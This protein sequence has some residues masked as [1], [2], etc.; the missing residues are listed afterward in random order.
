M[1]NSGKVIFYAADK[2]REIMLAR[3]FESGVKAMGEAFEIRRKAEYGENPDGSDRKY[4]GPTPDDTAVAICFGVKADQIFWDHRA[5]GIPVVYIDKGWSRQGG[6]GGHTLYSRCAVNASSPID[7]MMGMGVTH[8]RWER[9]GVRLAPYRA[10]DGGHI[11]Y[12]SSSQKYHDF[13]KLG[14]AGA[15]A[16]KTVTKLKK[17]SNRAVIYRP[18]PGDKSAKP[19]MGA[20]LS[21]KSQSP[22]EA[23][24]G[25][26]L[27]VTFGASLCLDALIAGIP[28]IV[29]GEGI[30]APVSGRILETRNDIEAPHYPNDVERL[31]FLAGMSYCQWT[32]DEM[33]SGEAWSWLRKEIDRQHIAKD[34]AAKDAPQ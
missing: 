2:P 7:Y 28:S 21:T 11:I 6:E 8:D 15:L 10:N 32:A 12:A 14:D 26:H 25:C 9:L 34:R 30:T 23:M 29:L 4:V 19:L 13:H 27:V 24:R 31:K 33:R 22:A 1:S 17:L 5:L 3:A 18:K 20:A 16:Q